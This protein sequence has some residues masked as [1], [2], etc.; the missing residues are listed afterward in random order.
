MLSTTGYMDLSK[1]LIE[2]NL[3][4]RVAVGEKALELTLNQI[5]KTIARLEPM[6]EKLKTKPKVKSVHTIGTQEESPRSK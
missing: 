6:V 2:N 5:R 3:D 1:D 4:A